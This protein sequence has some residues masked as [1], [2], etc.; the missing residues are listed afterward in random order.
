MCTP[1]ILSVVKLSLFIGALLLDRILATEK[2]TR[3]PRGHLVYTS[4]DEADVQREY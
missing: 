1:P 2:T 3:T 4:Y